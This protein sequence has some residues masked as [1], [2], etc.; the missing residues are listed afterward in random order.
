MDLQNFY[1]QRDRCL[2]DFEFLL[3]S[4]SQASLTTL[5][6]KSLSGKSEV[7]YQQRKSI[8]D[9]RSDRV[10][11]R[12]SKAIE[13]QLKELAPELMQRELKVEK[14]LRMLDEQRKKLA[15]ERRAIEAE[16]SRLKLLQKIF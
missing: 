4:S 7:Y 3:D 16:K 12:K 6:D 13:R 5:F 15:D 2:V 14:D 11:S 10:S 8:L 1:L 9:Y